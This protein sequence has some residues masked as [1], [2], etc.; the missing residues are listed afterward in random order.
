MSIIDAPLGIRAHMATSWRRLVILTT[1]STKS[2]PL[3]EP[4]IIRL[5]VCFAIALS[6]AI[7]LRRFKILGEI[8]KAVWQ[9]LLANVG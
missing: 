5:P 8:L 7:K 6:D 3:A 2:Q 9:I 4:N 1:H